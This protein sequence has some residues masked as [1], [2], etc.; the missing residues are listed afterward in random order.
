MDSLF[1]FY[2][3]IAGQLSE[4]L[5][6]STEYFIITSIVIVNVSAILYLLIKISIIASLKRHKE[7]TEKIITEKIEDIFTEYLNEENSLEKATNAIRALLIHS[8]Q[9][10]VI[11]IFL[12]Y[13]RVLSG[14]SE[15]KLKLLTESTGL[16]KT[17]IQNLKNPRNPDLD[18]FINFVSVNQ[19][20]ETVPFL[21]N[22][23][24]SSNHASKFQA[25][26]ALIEISQFNALEF[27]YESDFKL[28][29][30]EEMILLEKLLSLPRM[31]NLKMSP[32]LNSGKEYMI[33]LS[34][35]LARH[36][37]QFEI[38]NEL[39]NLIG[40]PSEKVRKNVYLTASSLFM[41]QL[42]HDFISIYPNETFN[43]KIEIIKALE[44]I[45]DT[46]SLEFLERIF[47]SKTPELSILAGYAIASVTGSNQK[48]F[49]L[50]KNDETLAKMINH[51]ND[52]L[53]KK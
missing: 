41:N 13:F 2:K 39:K 33:L 27:I 19:I 20:S 5:Y 42:Q 44:N 29:E 40:N 28:N 14:S 35:R 4:W 9:I 6:H 31:A 48:L 12:K 36:F 1:S 32:Y 47:L 46:G 37:N 11:K 53:I 38:E 8:N 49:R 24:K 43:N 22:I 34:L 30:W 15:E 52:P 3:L 50:T 23:L 21:E 18:L 17:V 7:H 25:L 16:N 26:C 45:G 10:I 51:I